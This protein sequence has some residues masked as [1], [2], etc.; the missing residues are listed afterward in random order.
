MIELLSRPGVL[1]VIAGTSILGVVSGALG[2]FALLRRQSLLGDA[3]AHAALP[4]V[5]LGFITARALGTDPKSPIVLLIGALA[6]AGLGTLVFLA[7]VR[8]TRLKTDAAIG[9]VLSVFFGAGIVLLTTPWIR[10]HA[11]QA[12]LNRFLFGQAASLVPHDVAVMAGMSAAVLVALALL[13][14]EFQAIT[15]DAAH[16]ASLGFPVRRLELVLTGLIVVAVVV[17]LQTVGVVLMAAM[18]VAPAA[19]ARQWTDRL[20]RMVFLSAALGAAAGV[21]GTLASGLAKGL[22]TGPMIVLAAAA[23]LL[24]SLFLAPARGL[25]WDALRRSRARRTVRLENLLKDLWRAAEEKDGAFER[26]RSL[27]EIGRPAAPATVRRAL[28]RELVVAADGDRLAL[29][30]AG[31][32]RAARV[33]RNHRLWECYLSHRLEL[34]DDHLHRDAEDMEHVLDERVLAR[35]DAALGYPAV[36]PHGRAIPPATEAGAAA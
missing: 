30:P 14:K 36:D 8:R 4:G 13:F 15:F 34:A 7:I 2:C 32:R 24:V 1:V 26:P 6:S 20:G 28:A 19:A 27:A 16:A 11:D 3:L 22:P 18:I 23:L 33:V 9:I 29:T 10:A 25:G 35:I 5:C 31:A 12:G 21:A 17:G